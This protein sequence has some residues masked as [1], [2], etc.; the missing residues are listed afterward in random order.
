MVSNLDVNLY[1]DSQLHIMEQALVPFAVFR[2]SNGKVTALAV[3]Q[4]FVDLFGFLNKG[5]AY[6]SLNRN[7]FNHI[8]SEDAPVLAASIRRFRNEGGF[9]DIVYRCIIRGETRTIH[10]QGRHILEN[11]DEKIAALWYAD[12]GVYVDGKASLTAESIQASVQE[13]NVYQAT[14]YDFLTGLPSMTH[15]FRLATTGR[16]TLRANGKET[17]ILFID[18]NGMKHYNHRY[19]FAEGDRMIRL[20]GELL[21][22]FF[23]KMNCSRF[24]QD[25]FAAFT[26]A[27]G[28][29]GTLKELFLESR[30]LD[31][32][33]QVSI[34]VGIYLDPK[35]ELVDPSTACDRAKM[36]CDVDKNQF[37]SH[38]RYFNGAMLERM[39]R[40]QYILDNLSRAIG[41]G[42]IQVYFQPIIRSANGRVSDEEALARW[43]DPERGF[44]S[45]ADFIPILEDAKLIYLLD[46]HI[47]ELVL[48]KLKK[49]EASGLYVVPQSINLSRT[50]FDSCDIVSEIVKRVDAAGID[51]SRINIEITESVVGSDFEFMK[52]QIQRFQELGFPVWMDDFGSGYSSLDVLQSVHFDL[53]KL[54]MR[55]MQRFEESRECRI[56]LTEL[57]KLGSALGIDT[58]TEGVETKEQADFL[59][60]VGCTKLQGYYFTKPISLEN[61]ME[62]YRTGTA[63]GFENPEESGYYEAVGRL[64][65]HDV[66][67]VI[68]E[69]SESFNWN[70][71]SFPMA[72]FETRG[73]E[74]VISRFNK[75]FSDFAKH[76]FHKN[77]VT[78]KMDLMD[79]GVQP[80]SAYLKA[81]R[82]C[83]ESGGYA[84]T[85][86]PLPTGFVVH[87]YTRRVAVNPIDGTIAS[88]GV[89][90]GVT[91]EQTK[92][93]ELHVGVS[94]MD[95]E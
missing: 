60:E 91:N 86:D 73:E 14:N 62:R 51:R 89:V 68:V 85:D 41:E 44:L 83:I 63:I 9:L 49:Q 70:L 42:W 57:I 5:E 1:D 30:K 24:G 93:K 47:L 52:K 48:D 56:I 79:L 26:A 40:Q 32:K 37:E 39:E 95:G 3:S 71:N 67:S 92:G 6:E 8:F 31:V 19:G 59:R 11:Q 69:G 84:V 33:K 94:R 2:F 81:L 34:R 61:I 29:E 80:D 45:P 38:F 54:D 23:G 15:F 46:L 58:I 7:I 64:N 66:S 88:A 4:G 75:S 77:E 16:E 50:D 82:Q 21:T 43:I 72:V 76:C 17:A 87:S 10:A 28:L 25:H 74:T 55:F 35:D 36:A 22:K 18:L 12:E 20:F 27:E 78:E 13:N 65:L 90:L 53:I